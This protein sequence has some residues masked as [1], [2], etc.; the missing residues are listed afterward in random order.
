MVKVTSGDRVVFPKDG[1]TKGDVVDY[2]GSVS[3]SL[4][5]YLEGRALTVERYPK[6]ITGEGFMQ[7]NTPDHY[8]D[9]IRRHRVAKEDGGTTVYPVIE[10]AEA[11]AF[12]A[13]HGVITFHVPP[14]RA[15]A[16]DRPD[17]VIWDLDPSDDGVDLV[18]RAAHVM[19]D[20][21]ASH[22]IEVIP[23][24]SGSRGYHL[25][26]IVELGTSAE[27]VAA[28]ARGA[29][30]LASREHDDLLTVEFHKKNRKGRVFVDWLRNAPYSTAVAPWSLRARDG[31]PVATPLT[32]DDVDEVAPADVRM[33]DAISRAGNDPWAGA[34][35][36]DIEPVASSV[37][38]G[39]EEAGIELPPFDRFRP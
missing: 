2:Y 10:D 28:M 13:N 30:V 22:G 33:S 24:T 17:W 34:E 15:D 9:N 14:V 1:I 25:R 20:A 6:G 7:K 39:L 3:P 21:L 8:P 23:M 4:L 5:P 26:A 31:A 29:A 37:T 12:F 27:T 16:P 11:I 19:R 35:P 36:I 32:W 18:R 38:A